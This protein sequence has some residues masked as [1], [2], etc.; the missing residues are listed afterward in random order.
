ME[1]LVDG[2]HLVLEREELRLG[3]VGE[4]EFLLVAR[5]QDLAFAAADVEAVDGL[6][7][8]VVAGEGEDLFS[9]LERGLVGAVEVSVGRLRAERWVKGGEMGCHC[10]RCWN[11][12]G[13]CSDSG[14][15]VL[16]FF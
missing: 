6:D 9:H 7:R 10:I 5:G 16:G 4:G 1:A 15:S 8:E 14:V 13:G 3:A 2:Q 11:G 12:G